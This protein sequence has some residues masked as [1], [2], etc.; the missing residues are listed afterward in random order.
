MSIF[1]RLLLTVF[2]A[3]T[4]SLIIGYFGYYSIQN[5]TKMTD[6]LVSKDFD[7]LS[8]TKQMKIEALQHRRYE[9]DFFLNI[10]KPEKQKSY[11]EKFNKVSR[12]L[13]SRMEYIANQ[14][15]KND[16][17]QDVDKEKIKEAVKAYNVY[18]S[19]FIKLSD[20]VLADESINPQKG[21][22]LM[23]PFKKQIYAFEKAID[24][25]ESSSL[26][27]LAISVEHTK[28]KGA[29][30][31]RTIV[32]ILFLGAFLILLLSVFTIRRIR[33]G[34]NV[35]SERLE[36]LSQGEGDLTYRIQ[37]KKKDEIGNAFIMLNSF[38]EKLQQMVLE[39]TQNAN[40][41]D[42]NSKEL[43]QISSDLAV[44]TNAS[45][46]KLNVIK[47]SSDE[48][49]SNTSTIAAA[50]EESSTNMSMIA[51]AAEQMGASV[52]EI[53]QNSEKTSSVT[54][55]TVKDS[56][57]ASNAINELNQFS[58]EIGKVTDVISEISDQTNL[59]ALNATIEAARAGEAGKGFAVVANE[60]KDLA[61][62]TADATQD[63]K[64]Q[65]EKVQ[66]GIQNGSGIVTNISKTVEDVN[67]MISSVAAATEEQTATTG[68]I[69][70][71]V[72]EASQGINEI[73][74]NL[75]HNASVLN[76]VNKEISEMGLSINEIDEKTT[77]VEEKS[78]NLSSL[79][80][81]LIQM[82]GK[83]KV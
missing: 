31:I 41:L 64:D 65:I 4:V 78:K 37:I 71:N 46:Q 17:A 18:Y 53:A 2:T 68:E 70:N 45:N 8:N 9:K 28:N 19:S 76:D 72:N 83:F 66:S 23:S 14:L 1:Q 79:S 11:I 55:E 49:S 25:L 67:V 39:I 74:E 13:K 56:Q 10:G 21:N 44:A 29:Q 59:L 3:V 7:Y 22:K 24:A 30:L 48:V 63:I 61:K 54:N 5:S 16:S 82:I 35:L 51:A 26:K 15:E 77:E 33:Y 12:S 40:N 69:S 80:N 34:F 58:A 36:E 57:E 42:A 47:D 38:L 6:N 20:T 81:S 73:N 32:I 50:M 43:S 62:Q 52:N 60:I 75:G 27:E